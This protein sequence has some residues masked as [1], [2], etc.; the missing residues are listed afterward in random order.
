MPSFIVSILNPLTPK[1]DKIRPASYKAWHQ[2]NKGFRK[3]LLYLKEHFSFYNITKKMAK[4]ISNTLFTGT[5]FNVAIITD[6]MSN[7]MS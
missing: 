4:R 2:I 5:T 3:Q 1:K 7:G 6:V